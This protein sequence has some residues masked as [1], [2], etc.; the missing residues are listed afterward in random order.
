MIDQRIQNSKQILSVLAAKIST[1][2]SGVERQKYFA[3]LLTRQPEDVQY[4]LTQAIECLLLSMESMNASDMDFG[5]TG[6]N[7]QVWFRINAHKKPIL[8]FGSFSVNEMDLLLL[9]LLTPMQREEFWENGYLQFSYQIMSMG[10]GPLRS[11]ATIYLEMDY[12]ALSLRR[13]GSEVRPF[14]TLGLNKNIAK[15]MSMEYQRHGIILITGISGSGKSSTLDTI[16][17]ANNRHSQGHI[18]IIADPLEYIHVSQ[19]CV[20]RQRE[21]GRDV[22]SFKEGVDNALRQDPDIIVI[23]EV[24]NPKTVSAALEAAD[25]GHKVFATL[26]TS[27]AVE[28]IDRILGEVTPIEQSRVRDRLATLLTCV[29]SQKLIPTEDGSLVLAKEILAM[30]PAVCSAIRNNNIEDIY[31]IIHQSQ[32]EGML[33]LEQDLA[34][35]CKKKVISK[36]TAMNYANNRRRLEELFEFGGKANGYPISLP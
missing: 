11:R 14:K 13:I 3:K 6:C 19:K 35:L 22:R 36:S 33:T 30:N 4:K 32:S 27:S 7:G 9:N 15:L 1:T 10:G 18:V 21:V 31:Q 25:T 28:S 24:R 16:V 34:R 29:I 26:H 23:G 8:E 20:V 2:L 5:G 12:I 17:D